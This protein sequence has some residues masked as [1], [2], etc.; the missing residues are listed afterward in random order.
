[1][2]NII[3]SIIIVLFFGSIVVFIPSVLINKDS[4]ITKAS[5]FVFFLSAFMDY[6][7]IMIV[8]VHD[9]LNWK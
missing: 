3:L 1:M 4:W 6:V 7:Y 8:F 5:L 9:I 2:S